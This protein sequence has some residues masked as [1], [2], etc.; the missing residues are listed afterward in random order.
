MESILHHYALTGE[1]AVVT[2]AGQGIGRAIATA[3]A[4]A[5]AKVACLDLIGEIAKRT[6]QEISAAGGTA[7]RRCR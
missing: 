4:K 7:I 6:A 3:F 1:V 2:G 5:G